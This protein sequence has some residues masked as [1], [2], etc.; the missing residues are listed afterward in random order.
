MKYYYPVTIWGIIIIILSSIGG[1]NLPE[2]F[3]D[4]IALDKVAHF[5][6]YAIFVVLAFWG[7]E[8]NGH[9]LKFNLSVLV[10]GIAV[11]LGILM[12]IMQYS[13]FPNRYFE[14]YDII[15]NIIGAF[16]GSTIYKRFFI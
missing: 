6:V 7:A 5:G 8:K 3:W 12:E 1:V 15:A 2:S 4:F 10:I 11:F 14:L 9:Y 13:F 16:V